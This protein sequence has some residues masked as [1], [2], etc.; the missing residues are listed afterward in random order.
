METIMKRGWDGLLPFSKA[1]YQDTYFAPGEDYQAWL[2]RVARAYQNDTEHGD[3]MMEYIQNYYFHPSTPVSSNAGLPDRGLPIACYTKST[4]D[5]KEGIFQSWLEDSYLGALGGGVGDDK[6]AIRE[7]NHAVGQ[8]GGKS[9]GLTPF[10]VVD[11]SLTSAISQGGIR[12]FSKANYLRVDHPEIIDHIDI[13]KPTGDQARRA[14]KLHHGIIITDAFMEAVLHDAEWNLI[15]PK[16]NSIVETVQARDLWTRILEVRLTLKGEPY[17]L[18]IDTVNEL[19]PA[20]YKAEGIE[21]TTSNLCSEIT[22]RTD[23]KHSGVCCLGSVNAEYF[24][25]WKD[26]PT[27]IADCT[28]FLDNVLQSFIDIAKSYTDPLKKLAFARVIAGAEDERSIGL[29]VMGFHS[30]LQSK[31]IPWESAIAKGANMQIFNNIKS[32]ADAHNLDVSEPCPMSLRTAA[33]STGE[34]H[35]GKRNIHVTAIAPTMSISSLCNVTSSGIEPWITNAFT[36]KVNQGSFAITNKYLAKVISKHANST[37][38][39][40]NVDGWIAE[41]WASIKKHDGSVQHLDWMDQGTKDVF[42]TAFEIAQKWIIEFAGDRAPLIDQA[43]S[44][45]VFLPGG[46]HVQLVSDLHIL[47]WKRKLKSLYYLRSSVTNRAST[48]STDR[49]LIQTQEVDIMEDTCQGC[50]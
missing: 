25:E 37:G 46:S 42:K 26:H 15:S 39:A 41:Q 4:A 34:P 12:R 23:E 40:T 30:Y 11:G 48:A 6:S 14:P 38:L 47:A 22:L 31:M 21:V 7:V 8:H 44:V 5:T 43:Q 20:E 16:D 13:R 45:N 27:F 32:K 9:S 17:L 49:K 10:Q 36:K 50:T 18:F 28:D 29:G 2:T 1:L 24:D 35:G 19:A 3:R 33:K